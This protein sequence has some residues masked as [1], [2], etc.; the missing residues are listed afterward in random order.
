[1]F[2][3][4][5]TRRTNNIA[6]T[7]VFGARDAKKLVLSQKPRY[8]RR[9]WT[10]FQKQ[11]YSQHFPHYPWKT[12][13]HLLRLVLSNCDVECNGR[14]KTPTNQINTMRWT[15]IYICV[16]VYSR[17][18]QWQYKATAIK[19]MS[20]QLRLKMRPGAGLYIHTYIYTSRYVFTGTQGASSLAI[21]P[22]GL[23]WRPVKRSF[24][25]MQTVYTHTLARNCHCEFC[26]G[27]HLTC[28]NNPYKPDRRRSLEGP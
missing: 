27:M 20:H 15:Y 9:F 18:R 19:Y 2:I 7:Y 17:R 16:C 26:C 1:M 14:A 10:C 11:Q 12:H 8:L 5:N 21:D 25:S 23:R 13:T 24:T 6:N 28:N 3:A 4:F 22:L